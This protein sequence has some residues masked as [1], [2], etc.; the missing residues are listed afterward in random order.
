MSRSGFVL[1]A[2]AV[3][4]AG[5]GPGAISASRSFAACVPE[6]DAAFCGRLGKSC[7]AVTGS[8]NCGTARSVASCGSCAAP[9]SCAGKGSA[10]V[11]ETPI[12][13]VTV[14][15]FG[16]GEGTVTSSRAGIDC[17]ASCSA[18]FDAGSLVTLTAVPKPS[19][20][21]AGFSGDCTGQTCTLAVE[22]P[23]NVTAT[24]VPLHASHV[25]SYSI[26][27][28][29]TVRTNPAAPLGCRYSSGICHLDFEAGTV[30]TLTASPASSPASS[31]D[32]GWISI[33]K[34]FVG[35]CSGATCVV[36]MDADRAVTVDFGFSR[37]IVAVVSGLSGGTLVLESSIDGK[38]A[39]QLS[40]SRNGS[41]A[42]PTWV[43]DNQ[44]Y[45]VT[46]A[47]LPD[48]PAQRCKVGSP[49][50]D[51]TGAAEGPGAIVLLVTCEPFMVAG[52]LDSP[53]RLA[54]DGSFLYFGSGQFTDPWAAGQAALMR[55]PT[56]GSTPPVELDRLIDSGPIASIVFDRTFVYWMGAGK[57]VT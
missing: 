33:F 17:A 23:K 15:L 50:S 7:D 13:A 21:F 39:E 40:V 42:F 41:H 54:R 37:S 3:A 36:P 11:C 5:C 9:Q 35:D 49:G 52:G 26:R 48:R 8:D 46:I 2:L 53:T 25:L 24:F 47:A 38:P 30:V 14:K 43:S 1:S 10:N 16:T 18:P 19:S 51:G 6:A 55:V 22:G 45:A 29:G 27:G 56:D 4:A 57:A 20:A 32:V 44:R 31:P 34:G 12:H 28:Y